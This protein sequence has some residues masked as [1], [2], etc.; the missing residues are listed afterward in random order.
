MVWGIKLFHHIEN[1]KA[2]KLKNFNVGCTMVSVWIKEYGQSVGFQSKGR[3]IPLQGVPGGNTTLTKNSWFRR[4]CPDIFTIRWLQCCRIAVGDMNAIQLAVEK[5]VSVLYLTNIKVLRGTGF[6]SW[7]AKT[8]LH[9]AEYVPQNP[10]GTNNLECPEN[11][12]G[13]HHAWPTQLIYRKNIILIR[14][15]GFYYDGVLIYC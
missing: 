8:Q 6:G 1:I 3:S 15:S 4:D 9:M 13:F 5:R 7:S 12:I 11:A 2:E 10:T 14:R